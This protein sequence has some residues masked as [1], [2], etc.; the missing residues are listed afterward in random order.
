MW[1]VGLGNPGPEYRF[2][3]HNV[4]FRVVDM[5]GRYLRVKWQTVEGPARYA[6]AEWG[7]RTIYLCL[8]LG[9]MNRSGEC[10]RVTL[11]TLH[12][13]MTCVSTDRMLVI[14]DDIDLPLGRIRI[15]RN[16]GS[17]GHRGVQSIIECLGMDFARIRIGIGRPV[18]GVSVVEY[19]LSRFAADERVAA[20]RALGQAAR[21]ALKVIRD[22]LEA[23]M[24]EYHAR[25]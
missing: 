18:A 12:P 4:G 15:K 8:P 25:S 23:A 22:G 5:L 6:A 17:A 19:V 21:A 9:Y 10:L 1:V 14:H 2:T 13:G 11:H 7:G 24:Q 16:G 3:R 20:R